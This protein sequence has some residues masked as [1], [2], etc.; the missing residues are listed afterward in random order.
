MIQPTGA[1]AVDTSK[2]DKPMIAAGGQ[3]WPAGIEDIMVLGP[4][5]AK[6]GV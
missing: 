3:F 2:A 1:S 5:E 6:T 4:G